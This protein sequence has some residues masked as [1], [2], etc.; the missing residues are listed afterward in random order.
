MKVEM[1]FRFVKMDVNTLSEYVKECFAYAIENKVGI[2]M[3]YMQE[4]WDTWHSIGILGL[5]KG[6]DTFKKSFENI[7]VSIIQREYS[8]L[9]IVHIWNTIKQKF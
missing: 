9:E 6:W 2:H 7:G 8:Y 1:N 5:P 4:D 3:G